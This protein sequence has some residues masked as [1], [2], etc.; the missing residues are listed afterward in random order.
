M[1]IFE[2]LGEAIDTHFGFHNDPRFGTR[3]NRYG[4]TTACVA[5]LERY[6]ESNNV[7]VDKCISGA[8]LKI[9]ELLANH[10]KE[11]RYN[12]DT[13]DWKLARALEIADRNKSLEKRLEK[14]VVQASEEHNQKWF[15]QIPVCNSFFGGSPR[16]IDLV[17][18]KTEY[19]FD[20]V[21]LKFGDQQNRWGSDTP[22]Y[23]ALE[24]VTY[25][26]FFAIARL[27]QL[28]PTAFP[29][30][31]A[32]NV[33][34]TVLAPEG[35]YS[36]FGNTRQIR[37]LGKEFNSAVADLNLEPETLFAFSFLSIPAIKSQKINDLLNSSPPSFDLD[38][39]E[40]SMEE[41]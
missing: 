17:R 22:L 11:L 25:G 3:P 4:N 41:V 29:L 32:K 8:I 15:N 33:R 12:Q 30:R 20:F 28:I 5:I 36:R 27:L 1:N 40:R 38:Q 39:F 16:R 9:L 37:R 21:E 14:C 34:L 23:A 10:V 2:Q 31:A 35:W 24:I 7:D 6:S 19:D 18:Q 26:I 13:S